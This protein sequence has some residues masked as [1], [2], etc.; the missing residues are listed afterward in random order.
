M[1]QKK[2]AYQWS[3]R[4]RALH[5]LPAIPVVAFYVG[6]AYLLAV[7]SAYLAGAFLLLWVG[8]NW[9]VAGICA[10][11]PYR[12][13]YCPGL[14]QGYFAPFL[15]AVIYRN[16]ERKAGSRSSK[17]NLVALGVLGL[18]SYVFAFYWLFRLYWEAHP[19]VVL[20]LLALLIVHMPLSFFLLC[21]KCGYNDTCP[22]ANVHKAFKGASNPGGEGSAQS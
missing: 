8:V 3:K 21:P 4:D 5:L 19:L 1:S 17:A 12:G 16:G 10:G 2:Q 11:C 22:M 6:A 15:S 7:A 13:G 18:G 14:C 9:V 20:A